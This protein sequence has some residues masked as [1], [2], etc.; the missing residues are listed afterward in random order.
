VPSF[1]P[2]SSGLGRTKPQKTDDRSPHIIHRTSSPLACRDGFLWRQD[3]ERN[4]P[5]KHS[6]ASPRHQVAVLVQRVARKRKLGRLLSSRSPILDQHACSTVHVRV[7]A[8]LV[9]AR[10]AQVA[11]DAA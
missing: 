11:Q 8:D 2:G 6:Q 7:R 9:R 10:V 5:P 4:V 3:T 1:A